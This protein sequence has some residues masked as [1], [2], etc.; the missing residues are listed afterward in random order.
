[1][2]PPLSQLSLC[3]R[4]YVNPCRN[5][6]RTR[7]FLLSVVLVQVRR[8]FSSRLRASTRD[9]NLF[10]P[11]GRGS[12]SSMGNGSQKTSRAGTLCGEWICQQILSTAVCVSM[13]S[14]T[15]LPS[16]P[17]LDRLANGN[18]PQ[19]RPSLRS[20]KLTAEKKALR[21]AYRAFPRACG[22]LVPIGFVPIV[23][24]STILIMTYAER[25]TGAPLG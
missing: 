14:V 15:A 20:G 17:Q 24:C 3:C 6:L 10:P 16:R 21:N 13:N 8:A 18:A 22:Y 12:G 25:K 1:M 7:T 5:Y 23:V 9:G 2:L 4:K 11:T 19:H